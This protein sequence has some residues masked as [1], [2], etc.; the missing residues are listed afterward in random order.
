[1]DQ[2]QKVVEEF[3]H[4]Y[5]IKYGIELDDITLYF[6]IRVNE[7][8]KDLKRDISNIPSVQFRS[9]SHYFL[10]SLGKNLKWVILSMSLIIIVLLLSSKGSS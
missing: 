7:M 3:R 9:G 5:K 8:H 1:M 4:H 10:Y 6:F 2:Y